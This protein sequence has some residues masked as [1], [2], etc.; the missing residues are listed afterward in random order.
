MHDPQ[1]VPWKTSLD[2]E[3]SLADG[4]DDSEGF[5]SAYGVLAVQLLISLSLP[6]L[7]ASVSF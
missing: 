3:D 2:D 1:R 7:P 6:F 4:E 5:N